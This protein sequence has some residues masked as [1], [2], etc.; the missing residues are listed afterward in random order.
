MI[1]K[2]KITKQHFHNVLKSQNKGES[3]ETIRSGIGSGNDGSA[4]VFIGADR[5][6]SGP[7]QF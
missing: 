5:H 7:K 3:Y 2:T 1:G 6:R 4:E